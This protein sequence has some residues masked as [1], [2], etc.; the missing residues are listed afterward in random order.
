MD[1]EA[2]LRKARNKVLRLLT[3]RPRSRQEV[4][5]YLERKGF[6]PGISETVTKEME[7]Y[8]YIDDR[9][10][11]GDFIAY[12][13][14]R[15]NGLIRIRYELQMKGVDQ[16]VINKIIAEN[17][18]PEEDYMRIKEVLSRREPLH[19]EIDQRWVGRQLAFL[20]R[21]GFQDN[22]IIK[23]LKEYSNFE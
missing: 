16:Q 17:F 4:I 14:S 7:E 23:A 19:G 1:E 12:R 22:L 11:T 13:K 9:R 18:D 3:Y 10:F 21:R 20:K 5:S 2:S 6:S 8:G 15:G